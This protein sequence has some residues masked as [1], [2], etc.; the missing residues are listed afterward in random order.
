MTNLLFIFFGAPAKGNTDPVDR[1]P[2]GCH[3]ENNE[4]N[5][6]DNLPRSDGPAGN[7]ADEPDLERIRCDI[8]AGKKQK[9][10][11]SDTEKA[12]DD[13]QDV[14]GSDR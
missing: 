13:P 1:E 4:A 8:D 10:K 2:D 7:R 6:H 12:D 14:L 5:A 11:I 3:Q 9:N